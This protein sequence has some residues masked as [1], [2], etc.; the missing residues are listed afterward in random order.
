MILNDRQ[1]ISFYYPP[2]LKHTRPK[3]KQAK[4]ETKDKITEETRYFIGSFSAANPKQLEHA[5]RAHWA[6]ENNLHCVLDMA[7]DVDSNR[8]RKVTVHRTLLSSSILYSI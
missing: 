2:F 1:D 4:R 8:T 6:V 3:N 7:F 5:I